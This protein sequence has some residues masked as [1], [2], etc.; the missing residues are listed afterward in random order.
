MSSCG[1]WIVTPG[2]AHT[3]RQ[4]HQ[5]LHPWC[6]PMLIQCLAHCMCKSVQHVPVHLAGIG[7]AGSYVA[8]E[9]PPNTNESEQARLVHL[10][11]N[12]IRI[13]GI[14]MHH[15]CK[16]PI[17]DVVI[18]APLGCLSP[19]VGLGS[20]PFCIQAHSLGK[21]WIARMFSSVRCPTLLN[22]K[23]LLA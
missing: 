7:M 23:Q 10:P 2:P 5:V 3:S 16:Q 20:Y 1:A 21:H 14:T 19:F 18:V 15:S 6:R 11:H 8:G 9:I 13:G 17:R 22:C 12:L 4:L